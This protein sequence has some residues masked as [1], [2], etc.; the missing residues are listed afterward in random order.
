MPDST[1]PLEEFEVTSV[2]VLMMQICTERSEQEALAWLRREH[3]SGLETDDWQICRG[4][5]TDPVPCRDHPTR[6]HYLFACHEMLDFIASM[7]MILSLGDT[8]ES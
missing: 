6:T 4:Q 7:A 5:G 8:E 2:R 1:E 3:P